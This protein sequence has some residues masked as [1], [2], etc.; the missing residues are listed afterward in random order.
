MDAVTEAEAEPLEIPDL[1]CDDHLE[2]Q[3]VIQHFAERVLANKPDRA[4][5]TAAV[6]PLIDQLQ[7]HPANRATN[8]LTEQLQAGIYKP[9]K[10][11]SEIDRR[12]AAA[13]VLNLPSLPALK[14]EAERVRL[15][16]ARRAQDQPQRIDEDYAPAFNL[17]QRVI[18][19]VQWGYVR[20]GIKH[21]LVADYRVRV[22]ITFLFALT[23]FMTGLLLTLATHLNTDL[24]G[25]MGASAF[26][27]SI[28]S[29]VFGA[30]FSMVA[31]FNHRVA[32]A[33]L[34]DME[35][36][37]EWPNLFLRLGFGA[38]AGMVLYF[39]FQADL[40]QGILFPEIETLALSQ[41]AGG[42]NETPLGLNVPNRDT[43]ALIVWSFVAGFS[44]SF[45]PSLLSRIEKSGGEKS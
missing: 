38:G 6:L 13:E 14:A 20:R 35:A 5:R 30:G 12:L 44:E 28:V 15:E 42:D 3:F 29:G 41:I 17:H 34:D 23:C 1:S 25:H 39:I 19:D 10:L 9:Q 36:L 11:M 18:S 22:Y 24:F 8:Y 4:A 27:L 16:L 43:A 31:L 45:V 21:D 26:G 40:L 32:P 37:K 33:A 2:R 7:K